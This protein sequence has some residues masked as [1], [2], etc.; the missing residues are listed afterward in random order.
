M[1]ASEREPF[2]LSKKKN[3]LFIVRH[4]NDLFSGGRLGGEITHDIEVAPLCGDVHRRVA[5][6]PGLVR[7]GAR[8]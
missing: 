4:G 7:I 2:R 1:I 8:L 5:I 3:V 6:L